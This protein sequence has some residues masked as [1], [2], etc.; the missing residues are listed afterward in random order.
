[1]PEVKSTLDHEQIPAKLGTEFITKFYRLL[2][3]ATLHDRKSVVVDRLTQEC[4]HVV[5][6][7]IQWEEKFLLRIVRDHFF[8]NDTRVMASADKYPIFKAFWQEMRKRRIGG[9]KFSEGASGEHL[10]D[11]AYLLSG[12]EEGQE[13]NFLAVMK[14][15]EHRNIKSIEVEK[16]EIFRDEEIDIDSEG[17][18]KYSR[19][20]YFRSI[21]L[22]REAAE[23][24]HQQN[25]LPIRKAKR[26]MHNAANA[27]MLDDSTLLGLAN[28]KNYDEYAFNHSVNVAIYAMALGQR[29]GI[30]KKHL[31]D[32][33]MAGLFHDIGKTKI[34]E[35]ILNKT[36]RLSPGERSI[37]KG[38]PV[39]G[40]ELIMK[41]TEWG[42]LSA[43]MTEG[44]FEHHL[45]YDLTGY[46]RLAQK[47]KITLFGRIVS[48]ADSYDA[49]TR[50]RGTLRFPYVSEKILE[51]MLE[52]SGKDFD[53]GIVKVF[54]NMIGAFPLGTLVLLNTYEMGIVAQIQ[55]DTELLDRPKVCLIYY[56]DGEYRKGK[57]VDLGERDGVSGDFKKSIVKTLDPNEYNIN[58]AEFFI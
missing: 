29:I 30:P 41:M 22:A 53:P 25:P 56:G 13:S 4:L 31:S 14:Q 48:I 20:V 55:E 11:L 8:F 24:I 1:M 23:S 15:L 36:E 58:V 34:P 27:I 49:L 12:L 33:G 38:H 51:I 28:N 45:R 54:I 21:G 40:A 2:K 52:R 19:E 7:I 39:I 42:E 18:K 50:P 43:R 6:G 26:L 32:L 16:L 5:N 3:G 35:E 17:R 46:P 44:A 47:K 9:L 10:K 57:V 37:M